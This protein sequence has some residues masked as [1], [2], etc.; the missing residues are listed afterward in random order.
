MRP[1]APG[2]AAAR[3]MFE[4]AAALDAS[5][6]P[7]TVP[8]GASDGCQVRDI[9]DDPHPARLEG[10]PASV[11]IEGGD[12]ALP[13]AV[14]AAGPLA[15]LPGVVGR[16]RLGRGCLV[17]LVRRTGSGS[18]AA[19]A[20]ARSRA[21]S[22][23]AAVTV[24]RSSA[25]RVAASS[26]RSAARTASASVRA[27][28]MAS[29]RSVRARRRSSWATPSASRA[30]TS[31][32]RA[33]SSASAVSPSVSRMEASVASKERCAS[34]RRDRASS[35]DGR[36]QPQALGDG[37]G[38]AAAGQADG[39]AIGRGQ[40]LEVELDRGVARPGVVWA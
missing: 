19:R 15:D 35:H 7:P 22:S 12:A 33:D 24:S 34:L 5:P 27:A 25:W 26:S 29:S 31:A 2:P 4:L 16:E 11:A 17:G 38:L 1:S 39:Q 30:R 28:R 8:L 9:H 13:A 21:A 36:R 18:R 23:E 32:A 10:R 40:R 37:E 20:S 6:P 14:A 3:P